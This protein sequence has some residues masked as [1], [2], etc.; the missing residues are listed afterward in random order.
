[1]TSANVSQIPNGSFVNTQAKS[2]AKSNSDSLDFMSMVTVSTDNS[3]AP[4]GT[5]DSISA[6]VKNETLNAY[7]SKGNLAERIPN[8]NMTSLKKSTEEVDEIQKTVQEFVEEVE[9]VIS[10]E[11][12]V[13][14][15]EIEEAVANLGM[16]LIDLTIPTEI[17]KLLGEL[18]EGD[19]I[20]LLLDDTV[21]NVL[22]EVKPMIDSLLETV[23]VET[24]EEFKELL[25]ENDLDVSGL[26]IL[27]TPDNLGPNGEVFGA[28]EPKEEVVTDQILNSDQVIQTV[29]SESLPTPIETEIETPVVAKAPLVSQ[30]EKVETELENFDFEEVVEMETDKTIVKTTSDSST[31]QDSSFNNQNSANNTDK[32]LLN[33]QSHVV[34]SDTSV[35]A[36]NTILNDSNI[37][38]SSTVEET[39]QSYTTIDVED[40]LNQIVTQTRTVIT[41]NSTTMEL[42]LHPA[43]LGK[44]YL[45]VT[46]NDGTI[47][48]KLYTQNHDV[49]A[50]METQMLTLKENWTQQG[51]KVNSVEI[52][53]GT[54]E[55]EEQLDHQANTAF[56]NSSNQFA[57]GREEEQSSSQSRIRN[58]NLSSYDELPEDMTEE[59]LLA[60][61]MMK[62]SG[63]S[64]NF[65]A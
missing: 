6:P 9:K 7:Q 30:Q 46:E 16:T 23:S 2:A 44:M 27:K 5:T 13:S 36:G 65:T 53:V 20:S 43:S 8:D 3:I 37:S 62:D 26:E 50:A 59:E 31:N 28:L 33:N 35:P 32:N 48:A 39:V 17:P 56:E 25:L 15:E 21:S 14:D 41:D 52:T 29:E 4:T 61:S 55:F 34:I 40:I 42:E 1:M 60:A 10:E 63:N 57:G 12:E 54:R 64:V 22:S 19:S 18:N 58:I 47:S 24:P 45:Q 11:L 51:L 49:K 38:F